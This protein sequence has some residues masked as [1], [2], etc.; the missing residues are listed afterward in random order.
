MVAALLLVAPDV[1]AQT[2]TPESID[3]GPE[4]AV[5]EGGPTNEPTSITLPAGAT[6][7]KVDVFFLFDDTGSFAD[8]SPGVRSVFSDLVAELQTALPGVDLGF[9]IGRFEDYGGIGA[10]FNGFGSGSAA[11]RPFI[12]N[13]AI[14]TTD[15]ADFNTLIDEALDREAPGG[16][17][18]IP[19]TSIA[20]G[21]YQA[22]T[23]V[24]FDADGDGSTTTDG[25]AGTLGAQT[26]TGG[27]KDV[28]SFD[29]YEG[30]ASGTLGGVGWRSDAQ[31]IVILAT[32]VCSVASYDA[33]EIPTNITGVGGVSVPSSELA[34]G[35]GDREG[36]VSDSKTE[37]DNTIA[38]A[39]APLGAGTVPATIEALNGLGVKVIGLAGSP[40]SGNYSPFPLLNGLARL[41]GAVDDAGDPLVFQFDA[42]SATDLQ[43][44][45]TSAIETSTTTEIDIALQTSALPDGLTFAASPAV[46]ENVGPGETASFTATFT[47][48]GDPIEG[49]FDLQFVNAASNAVIGSIPVSVTCESG[50]AEC[51][52][53]QFDINVIGSEDRAVLTADN[54]DGI[55]SIR[56]R[57]DEGAPALVN[58]TASTSTAN[59]AEVSGSDGIDWEYTG[60]AGSEPTEVVFNLQQIDGSSRSSF[61]AE[62]ASVCS[63]PD[64]KI[65]LLDPPIFEAK[66][67][68]YALE[69][70]YPNPVSQAGGTTFTF[71]L[72]EAAPVRLDV[73]DVMGRR[74]ATVVDRSMAAG[75][76]AVR[77]NGRSEVGQ[78]LAS[79]VYFYRLEAGSHV[80][81]RRLTVVR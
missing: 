67:A 78:P 25:N 79:G 30:T 9:G 57:D 75:D 63:D 21:L 60:A 23:G 29:T 55:L 14:I 48:D 6:S 26:A 28:P 20:E 69:G 52:S 5:C 12:L 46:V 80:E 62:A 7:D 68:R 61:F 27:A 8:V 16:G 38:G 44:A 49:V 17:F 45:V 36:F 50:V 73:Y 39:V 53:T 13:Q 40:A 51:Q 31:R 59:F 1:Q 81:T 24:G 70:N 33:D 10:G 76:H 42:S 56:F 37:A 74:V 77:W 41:T 34:C 64:P 18:D 66:I 54:T 19:E 71:R 43:A 3:I 11:N 22:A 15:V 35:N 4:A 65:T 2:V 47:G 32:D 72:P 58:F